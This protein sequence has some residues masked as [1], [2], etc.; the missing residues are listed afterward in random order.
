MTRGRARFA[1]V[2]AVAWLAG[3]RAARA[4]PAAGPGSA[5]GIAWQAPAACP[6][7]A[8]VRARV[9]QRLGRP[10]GGLVVGIHVDVAPLGGRY[11]A[12][13]ELAAAGDDVRTLASA[14]CDDLADAV[15]VIV[16]RVAR[17]ADTPHARRLA[18]REL[19][20]DAAVTAAA[21]APA[22][23]RWSA[24]V[25][26]SG[27]SGIGVVPRVGLAGEVAAYL[28]VDSTLGELAEM[29]WF[30]SSIVLHAGAPARVDVGLDATAA[31]LGWRPA[32]LPLRAW[33]SAEIGSMEGTGIALSNPQVGSGRWVAAGAG[34]GVAW[35]MAR[36]I[37]LVGATEVAF[38]FERAQFHLD[39]GAIVYVPSPM[40]ARA[41][42]GIEVGLP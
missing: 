29:R 18:M 26:L 14:R 24:G 34:F 8:S 21:P 41:T 32:H 15:A 36:W 6:D 40:S 3:A 13:V 5:S 4:E 22:E 30:A 20:P 12:R 16:A 1:V 35:P 10:L 39:D 28:R 11:V 37:R 27:V 25:R 33:V 9:E 19:E 42:L 17:A 23:R 31:R 2:L 7:V 38:A